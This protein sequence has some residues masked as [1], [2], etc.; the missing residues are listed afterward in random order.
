[1]SRRALFAILVVVAVVQLAVPLRMIAARE[2]ILDK[3]TLFKFRTVPVDPYDAFRG[4]Y[5]ALDFENNRAK[6]PGDA[7][8]KRGAHVFVTLETDADGFATLANALTARPADASYVEATVWRADAEGVHVTMP[9]ERYYL[10]ESLAP[11]A[12]K[13]Y[14]QHAQI[15]NAYIAVRILD[16]DAAI[17]ELYLDDT[18]VVE[19]LRRN[20]SSQED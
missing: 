1:M 18:P 20:V 14:Q 12:E 13:A 9:F 10:E 11:E 17:E 2:R 15:S 4:R 5:V 19:Y 6:T 8:F 7:L 16:G 3:G